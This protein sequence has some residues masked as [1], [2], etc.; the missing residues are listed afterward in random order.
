VLRL[1]N[2][3]PQSQ[4]FQAVRAVFERAFQ[5]AGAAAVASPLGGL[6]LQFDM[7]NLLIPP[8]IDQFI[9]RQIVEINDETRQAVKLVIQR[10]FRDGLHP[11][12]SAR[13]IQDFVGLHSRWANA[14]YSYRAQLIDSGKSPWRVEQLTQRYA[15]RLRKK[16]A[17]MIARTET[18]HA[19]NLGQLEA[20]KQSQLAGTL[21][22]TAKK[23]WIVTP[24]DRL[25]ER[26]APLRIHQPLPMDGLFFS[27]CVGFPLSDPAHRALWNSAVPN[28]CPPGTEANPRPKA[29]AEPPLHPNCRCSMV[30]SVD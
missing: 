9:G 25:C 21:P 10:A 28:S 29:K 7:K 3:N 5:Q 20:W 23:R 1:L 11:Y 16:R 13:L 22:L 12:E 14:V 17:R 24:D 18:L 6:V 2:I 27:Q 15:N 4:S 30:L 19:A 8:L 26:C